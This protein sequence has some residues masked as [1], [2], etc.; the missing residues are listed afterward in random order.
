MTI[1]TPILSVG[2]AAAEPQTEGLVFAAMKPLGWDPAV[3]TVGFNVMPGGAPR[4]GAT[5]RTAAGTVSAICY[6]ILQPVTITEIAVR[7]RVA[8]G[9]AT[10][11]TYQVWRDNQ[12]VATFAAVVAANSVVDV[13]DAAPSPLLCTPG[14]RIEV[15][16]QVAAIIADAD[17]PEDVAVY[18]F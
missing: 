1:F 15:V 18:L 4:F 5:A 6:V 12:P 11:I 7:H 14:Q 8:G 10:N 16:A 17:M 2:V 3:A 9:V 13:V